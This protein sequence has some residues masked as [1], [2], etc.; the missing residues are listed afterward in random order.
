MSDRDK[1]IERRLNIVQYILLFFMMT[2]LLVGVGVTLGKAFT[3]EE[4]KAK[5]VE[6]IKEEVI[7]SV[8]DISTAIPD[9]GG[10]ELSDR[11]KRVVNA[12]TG[13]IAVDNFMRVNSDKAVVYVEKNGEVLGELAKGDYV[14][15][16]ILYEDGYVYSGQIQGYLKVDD[17]IELSE[18]VEE[19]VEFKSSLVEPSQP[20]NFAELETYHLSMPSVNIE[21]EC[22][23]ASNIQ[24]NTDT[25]DIVHAKGLSFI[26]LSGHNTRSLKNLHN[27]KVGDEFTYNGVAY[28]VTFSGTGRVTEDWENV[29]SD[30]TGELLLCTSDIELITCYQ[31]HLNKLNRWVVLG[32]E[33]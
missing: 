20:N 3:A 26:R 14:Y 21:A 33:K 1:E 18:Y 17:L 15:V 8:G 24:E 7:D 22:T 19:T 23:Y 32:E 10:T 16:H 4:V 30:K 11:D 12:E 5:V 25:Y 29:I 27:V 28:L 2:F 9:L 31:T 6:P 13:G